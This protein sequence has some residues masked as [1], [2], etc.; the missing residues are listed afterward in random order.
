VY[1][2]DAAIVHYEFASSRSTAA[3]IS[4]QAR[5]QEIFADRHGA[6]LAK[7]ENPGVEQLLRARARNAEHRVLIIDDRVPHV[8]LGSGFPRA[9]ALLR[10]LRK[11]GY[12]V[13]LY[14]ID[15]IEEPWDQVYSDFPSEVEVMTDMGRPLL[16]LFLR[17]RRDYYSTIIV[18]RPHNM[19]LI[20]PYMRAHP[21][22][23]E[24]LEVIYDAEALYTEREIGLRKLSA[25]P[26]TEAEI[27]GALESELRLTSLADRVITVSERDRKAFL[28]HGIQNVEV[29]GHSLEP[30]PSDTPFESREGFLFVGAVHKDDSPNADSLV[31]FLEEI[32]P[33]IQKSLGDVPITIAGVNQSERIREM[34]AP[35][36][37]ITGHLPSLE[38]LYAQA[39]V[40]IA[41]T[42]FAAGIPHKVHEAAAHGLPVVA[43]RLL[44]A[45]LGWTNQELAI[46]EDAECFATQCI[47][48]YSH[49]TKW[50]RQRETALER[51]RRECTPQAFQENLRS[52]LQPHRPIDKNSH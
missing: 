13:T 48:L 15:V 51:I 38:D 21:D 4:L 29:L 50:Q 6:L 43:T 23:F 12:F 52:I 19:K 5:N 39:R 25:D 26:M 45:Q 1:E 22:W 46:A 42:R 33:R 30:A 44:A 32:Y 17:S 20:A 7:R 3:A 8:W 34:A 28:T 40:F 27:K 35:P 14:P 11:L 37:R 16:E 9:Q 36:V 10:A 24:N 18:S 31:W 2:P 47:E 41:P 49:P